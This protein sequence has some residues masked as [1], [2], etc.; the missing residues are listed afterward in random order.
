MKLLNAMILLITVY[1]LKYKAILSYCL[2]FKEDTKNASL[3]VSKTNNGKIMLISKS[4]ICGTKS[5][6][7]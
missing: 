5:K 7:Y 3:S 1:N 2:K 4:S 6:I